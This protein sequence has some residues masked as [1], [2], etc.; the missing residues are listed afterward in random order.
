MPKEESDRQ[1]SL[2]VSVAVSLNFSKG[3]THTCIFDIIQNIDLEAVRKQIRANQDEG[4]QALEK[5]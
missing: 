2:P 5:T 1:E 3:L 4:H